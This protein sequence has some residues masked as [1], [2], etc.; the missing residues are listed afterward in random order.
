MFGYIFIWLIGITLFTA[1]SIDAEHRY[2]NGIYNFLNSRGNKIGDYS[3]NYKEIYSNRFRILP[4]VNENDLSFLSGN[5]E[6]SLGEYTD[7]YFIIQFV[8]KMCY[9]C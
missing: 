3:P 8:L 1:N 2:L 4:S 5:D 7:S 6:Y 9:N